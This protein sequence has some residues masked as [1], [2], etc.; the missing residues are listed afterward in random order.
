MITDLFIAVLLVLAIFKGY[1]R[2][3]IVGLFSLVAIIIGL[4]AAIK[5]SAVVA[6]YIGQTVKIGESWLPVVSFFI[7]FLVVILL[8]RLGAKAIEK[9]V[10][11]ALLGWVNKLG[12]IILYII[13]YMLVASVILFYLGQIRL[14]QPDVID[15]SVTWPYVEPWGPRVIGAFGKVIPF[16]RDMFSELES[17]FG[18]V[19]TTVPP[20]K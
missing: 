11:L 10:E 8:V 13:L 2:G 5:L 4:A 19:A 3:L 12:G 9:T 17:F 20:A 16:F 18:N 7:V 15:D 14:L 1:S 6:G